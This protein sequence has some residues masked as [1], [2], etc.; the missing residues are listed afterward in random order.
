MFR[1]HRCTRDGSLYGALKILTIK[2]HS[3]F[4]REKKTDIS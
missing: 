4:F 1:L 2:K 3:L